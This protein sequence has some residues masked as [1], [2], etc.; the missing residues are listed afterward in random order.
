MSKRKEIQTAIVEDL[1]GR[2]VRMPGYLLPL[3]V[4]GAKVTEFL[5]VPYI[6]ACIHVPPPPPNQIVYVKVVKKAYPH[7]GLYD[8]VWVT[9]KMSVKSMSRDLFLV[10]GSAD[11]S[12]GYALDAK[13]VE[14]Y[15]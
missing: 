7:K 11:V 8:P 2:I 12:I 1:N 13:Q 4:I 14:P 15:E 5:L 9:G 3:D 6:G 10:D